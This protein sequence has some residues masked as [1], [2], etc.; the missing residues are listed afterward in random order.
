MRDEAMR[1][2]INSVAAKVND[3]DDLDP[4]MREARTDILSMRIELMKVRELLL[5]RES[6]EKV[7]DTLC[8]IS[9]FIEQGVLG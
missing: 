3:L 1:D 8:Q 7:D 4:A 2:H 6:L 5:I 9:C